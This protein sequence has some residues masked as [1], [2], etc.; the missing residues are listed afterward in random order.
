MY[1]M[2]ASLNHPGKLARTDVD[3]YKDDEPRT[4]VN[5]WI[6]GAA[7]SNMAVAEVAGYRSSR[8]VPPPQQQKK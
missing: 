4:R 2:L 5:N 1:I 8:K 6:L 7:K 3:L